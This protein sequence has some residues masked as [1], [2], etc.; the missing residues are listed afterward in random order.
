MNENNIYNATMKIDAFLHDLTQT[1]E[2]TPSEAAAGLINCLA[3]QI[4]TNTPDGRDV[5]QTLK[6]FHDMLRGAVEHYL[7]HAKGGHA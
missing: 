7:D 4:A 2:I 5:G 1:S 6:T 3:Y